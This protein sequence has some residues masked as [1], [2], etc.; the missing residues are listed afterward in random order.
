MVHNGC[1]FG[2]AMPTT[3]QGP[4]RSCTEGNAGRLQQILEMEPRAV[5]SSA[6]SPAG[7]TAALGFEWKSF[8]AQVEG[9]R[10]AWEPLLDA[11]IE[12]VVIRDTPTPTF[13]GPECVERHGADAAQCRTDRATAI[14][15]S[16][17]P[18]VAAAEGLSGVRV[19]DLTDHLCNS[20][21]C[22]GV[23]GNVLVYRD[24][25]VTDMF[26][27]SLQEPLRAAIFGGAGI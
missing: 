3:P 27:R 14:D 22:P 2:T 9:Y 4:L 8:E 12:V 7:Y 1:P 24:N 23:I 5:I 17:D 16:P 13:R 11:G 26:A 6:M 19:V 10:E 18:A 21:T 20:E 25:H 15:G